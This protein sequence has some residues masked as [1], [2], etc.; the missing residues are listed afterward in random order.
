MAQTA[1]ALADALKAYVG[2]YNT[3]SVPDQVDKRPTKDITSSV[4]GELFEEAAQLQYSGTL[5][6]EPITRSVPVL[7][8]QSSG[9]VVVAFP[10]GYVRHHSEIEADADTYLPQLRELLRIVLALPQLPALVLCGHSEGGTVCEALALRLFA[11]DSFAAL[12]EKLFV[13]TSG[14]HLWMSKSQRD[15]LLGH[16]AGRHVSLVTVLQLDA[17]SAVYDAFTT[18]SVTL[19]GEHSPD[20]HE[21]P[22]QA[23]MASDVTAGD[24]DNSAEGNGG[25]MKLRELF[26]SKG[27]LLDIGIDVNKARDFTT[28]YVHCWDTYQCLLSQLVQRD[29]LLVK[30]QRP[31][32]D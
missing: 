28:Q 25:A 2:V 18:L 10:F 23:M 31:R 15:S 22:Q 32:S 6:G 16:I 26:A 5:G 4:S 13:V 17:S 9:A 7:R 29:D 14:T 20:L 30:M 11:D 3:L 8:S 21:M 24:D 27:E 1:F 19:D 12:H